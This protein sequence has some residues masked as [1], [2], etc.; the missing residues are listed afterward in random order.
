MRMHV[1]PRKRKKKFMVL[2]KEIAHAL[3]HVPTYTQTNV[4]TLTRLF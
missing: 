1:R 2:N 3:I 4:Q